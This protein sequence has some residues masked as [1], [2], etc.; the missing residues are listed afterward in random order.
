MARNISGVAVA[1]YITTR[2]TSMDNKNSVLG[3]SKRMAEQNIDYVAITDDKKVCSVRMLGACFQ[4]GIV[5]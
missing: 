4:N 3:P 5:N 2:R 1:D